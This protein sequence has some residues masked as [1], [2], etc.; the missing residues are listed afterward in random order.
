MKQNNK[1]FTIIELLV[2]IAIIGVL[3][4]IVLVSLSSTRDRAQIAKILLYS[5]QIYHSLGADIA[6]NWN[7]DEGSGTTALDSSGYN[8]TGTI[9]NGAFYTSDTPHKAAGQGA[10]KYALSF[11]G[12][13]DYVDISSPIIN[14]ADPFTVEGWVNLTTF[15][16]TDIGNIM[17]GNYYGRYRGY[18]LN[19]YPS[20]QP[21]FHVGRQS[22]STTVTVA[23][24]DAITFNSWYHIMGVYDGTNAK[25]YVNGILKKSQAYSPVEPETANTR[26]GAGQWSG[27]RAQV[28]G[29]IDE[30]RIY[31]RALTAAEI[32][33]HY[34][35]GSEK[36][37]DL[38]IK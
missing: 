32:Q 37:K 1:S 18:I 27:I 31:S 20:G 24:P 2:V 38:A 13:D 30:V 8:N 28:T 11:D 22:D 29:F 36:H 19:V 15:T 12:A 16:S 9:M 26:I 25:I 35:E 23:S 6:G 3:A 33:Q 5:N 10:G 4:S 14:T 7:F 21:A 17:V 34:A